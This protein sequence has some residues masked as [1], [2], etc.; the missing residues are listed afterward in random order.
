[1]V[2][3]VGNSAGSF[4]R[5]SG[6]ARAERRVY[7][8]AHDRFDPGA[9]A[10]AL[11]GAQA[12]AAIGSVFPGPGTVIGGVVGGVIGSQVGQAAGT[13]LIDGIDAGVQK[14]KFW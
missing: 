7:G 1:M 11:M 12:G 4:S 6:L 14:L 3:C 10:G 9:Y 8:S 2:D 5:V 13:A